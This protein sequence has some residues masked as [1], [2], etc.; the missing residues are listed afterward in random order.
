MSLVTPGM[1][2][3]LEQ[4]ESFSVVLTQGFSTSDLLTG[5]PDGALWGAVPNVVG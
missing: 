2:T 5:G 1:K 3:M 4:H